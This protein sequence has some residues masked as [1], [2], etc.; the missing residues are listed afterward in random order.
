MLRGLFVLL[1]LAGTPALAQERAEGRVK[2]A[3]RVPFNFDFRNTYVNGDRVRFYGFR[4]GAQRGRDLLSVGFYGLGDDHVQRSARIEG[5]GERELHTDFDY[6]ALSYERLLVDSKRWQI[7][8]PFSIGLGTYRR[9]YL[10]GGRLVPLSVNELVP[11]EATLHADYNLLR[12][13]YFGMGG[14]YRHVLAADKA[15]TVTLS[16]WTWY[17]KVGLRLGVLVKGIFN[18]RNDGNGQGGR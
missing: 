11:L 2:A 10:E 9:S 8:I 13:L 14:G 15:A 3:F 6:A 16:D 4:L 17:A 12:W 5:I 18:G 1:L 7:G